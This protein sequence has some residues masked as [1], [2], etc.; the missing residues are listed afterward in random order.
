MKYFFLFFTILSVAQSVNGQS[1][2]DQMYSI[3]Y[4]STFKFKES[5]ER[6]NKEYVRLMVKNEKSMFQV[7]NAMVR[8]TLNSKGVMSSE[9]SNKYYTPNSYAIEMKGDSL[10]YYDEVGREEYVYK[11]QIKFD[12]DLINEQ[13]EIKGFACKKAML[14]YGGRDWVAWYAPEVT[15]NAGPYKFNGL[16]GLIIKMT[17]TSN[18]YDYEFYAMIEKKSHLL[19]KYYHLKP[20]G[21]RIKTTRME[22]NKLKKAYSSLSLNEKLS[23][24]NNGANVSFK[25][26]SLSGEE[27]ELR[28]PSKEDYCF[29]EIAIE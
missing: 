23:L 27:M 17:D 15:V 28:E 22:F 13:K 5:Q 16:P 8:D 10:T 19:E 20:E 12:W 6:Y 7:Y 14:T 9:L 21:E 3:T 1:S 18:L 26:T 24:L 2:D 25:M 11:E 29:I 4:L